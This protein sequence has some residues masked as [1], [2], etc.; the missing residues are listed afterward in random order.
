MHK[1]GDMREQQL[2]FRNDEFVQHGLD[3]IMIELRTV[4]YIE[5]NGMHDAQD[6]WVWF[7]VY[8]IV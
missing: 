3:H 5:I 1:T 8:V 7:Q 6:S 2:I 4:G